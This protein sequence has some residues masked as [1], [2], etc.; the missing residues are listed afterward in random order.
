[1]YFSRCCFGIKFPIHKVIEY[2][3]QL[4]FNSIIKSRAKVFMNSISNVDFSD[5][6]LKLISDTLAKRF[7]KSVETQLADIELPVDS[8]DKE[9][10]P[11]PAV[12][13]EE[14]DCHFILAKTSENKFFSQFFYGD[15]EQFVTEKPFYDDLHDCVM[16]LLQ[17]QADHVLKESGLLNAAS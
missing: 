17:V 9:L 12:Y 7:G 16:T 2:P 15:H 4:I 11:C 14:K 1:M 6:E 5:E 3:L 13:W 8:G 10:T